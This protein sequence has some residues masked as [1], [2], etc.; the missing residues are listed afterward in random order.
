MAG[1]A[2]VTS[3]NQDC[4]VKQMLA[5]ISHRGGEEQSVFSHARATLG[6]TWNEAQA[7]KS[8]EL[9][10]KKEIADEAGEGHFARCKVTKQGIL[11]E[12]DQLGVAPLYYAFPQEETVFFASEVKAL[13]PFTTNIREFPPGHRLINGQLKP[14]FQLEE[15]PFLSDHPENIARELN[16]LLNQS[17]KKR[18]KRNDTGAWLSGGLDSS[19]LASLAGQYVDEL[20]TFAAGLPGAPDLEYAQ[21]VAR[22]IDSK[23]HQIVVDF[24]TLLDVLPQVIYH[25]ESFDAWLVRSSITNYLAAQAASQYVTSV[26]SG[27]GGDELFGGYGYLKSI[28]IDSLP[29]ELIDIISRLHNT[30]LQRVDRSA[31]AYGIVAQVPLLGP[32]VVDYALRIPPQ[33][34]IRNGTEKWILRKAMEGLLPKE[35]LWR[36]K[37]KFWKGAGIEDLLSQHAEEKITDWDF[38]KE[39]TLPNGWILNSKEELMYYRIFKEHFGELGNLSWMGRSKKA[40]KAQ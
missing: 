25:L 29:G 37:V 6:I 10:R 24:N 18:V 9:L 31:A 26:F 30:A 32:Q 7:E 27:E 33:L 36:T 3:L 35:V 16:H 21:T 38:Q 2:G 11:L 39:K 40:S 15:K 12:R 14:Y 4:Q 23:H 34:K 17:V 19:T 28:A 20:H 1:I 13:L 22:F 5:K 8:R